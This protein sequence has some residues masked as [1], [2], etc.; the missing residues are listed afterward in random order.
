M[1]D[2]VIVGGGPAGATLARLLKSDYRVLIL[3]KNPEK[4]SLDRP[5]GKCCG[6]LIAPDAQRMLSQ[7]KLGLP[8]EV[9]V[10]PQIFT[11]R[12]LDFETDRENYYQR[13]Y[14]N[15]DR[16]RFDRWL[17]SLVP[18]NVDVSYDSLF[19][20]SRQKPDHIEVDIKKGLGR[21]VVQ[22]RVLIGADGAIS[23]VRK[24]LSGSGDNGES[25]MK[26]YTSVQRE[27]LVKGEVNHFGAFFDR[28]VTDYYSWL[29]PKGDS[30]LIGTAVEPGKSPK[31]KFD[32]LLEGISNAGYSP[33]PEISRQGT[34]LFRPTQRTCIRTGR[35]SIALVGE[36]A[37]FISPS[38]AEGISYAF[39]SAEMLA[40]SL[41][42]SLEVFQRRYRLSTMPLVN[43]IRLK[44]LKS[45]VMYNFHLRNMIFGTG[46]GGMQVG[47]V[48]QSS[49][50]S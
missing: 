18:D 8:S 21:E 28:S 12:A 34:L 46:F 15:V 20:N 30:V 38:S 9:L 23:K 13:F 19:M 27:F 45:R 40:D 7:F 41:N 39:R 6:G 48:A 42:T 2:I 1:Y 37:G 43:N 31:E 17:L 33:G 3:E 50:V 11:V 47:P 5:V 36:A 44:K 32:R 14:L 4:A 16:H 29:I 26:C 22:T 10:S 35:G 49:S 24:I 25:T